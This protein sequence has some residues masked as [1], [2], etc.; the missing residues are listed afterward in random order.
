MSNFYEFWKVA[1]VKYDA[2]QEL[3]MRPNAHLL[4]TLRSTITVLVYLMTN[5]SITI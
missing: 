1:P 4:S 3:D 5:E 2:F